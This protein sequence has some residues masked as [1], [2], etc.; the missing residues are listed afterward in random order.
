MTMSKDTAV[1]EMNDTKTEDLHWTPE[2]TAVLKFV[3]NL[4]FY[5]ATYCA[6]YMGLCIYKGWDL[7][8]WFVSTLSLIIALVMVTYS[9]LF[10]DE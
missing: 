2:K 4:L 8:F 5:A 10:I 1:E 7:N 9:R 6:I 3:F